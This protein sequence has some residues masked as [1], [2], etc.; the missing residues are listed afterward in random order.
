MW[1]LVEV[2]EPVLGL[3]RGRR[4]TWARRDRVAYVP[5]SGMRVSVVCRG[6]QGLRIGHRSRSWVG[7]HKRETYS[8]PALHLA[9][10]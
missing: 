1:A 4:S 8:F 9:A 3:E 6:I 10:T 2:W 7:R 5:L